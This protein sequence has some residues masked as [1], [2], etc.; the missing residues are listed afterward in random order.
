[1]RALVLVAMVGL[2]GCFPSEPLITWSPLPQMGGGQGA[3]R[4]GQ[5][6]NRR[7][8]KKGGDD[9]NRVGNA[10]S[11]WGIPYPVSAMD[12][13]YG[14]PQPVD[15]TLRRFVEQSLVASGINP[16]GY[17]PATSTMIIEVNEL[18]FDGYMNY[19]VKL[20]LDLVILDP[21]NNSIR[22][23]VPLRSEGNAGHWRAAFDQAFTS[24]HNAAAGAFRDPQIRAALVAGGLP[25]PAAPPGAAAPADVGGCTKDTDCKGDRVCNRGRCVDP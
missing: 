10:R 14:V 15:Q 8:P 12:G 13:N 25:P 1:M 9:L 2:G 4:I 11:G 21:S 18:W 19:N 16:A 22:A 7:E 23:R 17:G 24:A 6:V 3:V 5:I 20:A